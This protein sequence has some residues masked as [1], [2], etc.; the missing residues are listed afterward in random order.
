MR[1]QAVLP[2]IALA[3][4]LSACQTITPEEQR[5]RDVQTCSGYGFKRGSD[6]FANCLLRLDLDRRAD[7]RS[8]RDSNDDF[9]WGGPTVIVGGGYY[10]GHRHWH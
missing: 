4:A 8:F 3:L 10:G 2:S 5:T 1:V 6:G 7:A 9:F